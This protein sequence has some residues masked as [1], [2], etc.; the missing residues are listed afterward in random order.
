M[1]NIGKIRVKVDG[2][3]TKG[4]PFTLKTIIT[5]PNNNGLITDP[6]T[7]K[8]EPVNYIIAGEIFLDSKRIFKLDLSPGVSNNPYFELTVVIE[9]ASDLKITWKDLSGAKFE[10]IEKLTVG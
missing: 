10:Q 9:K 3:I 1:A 4:K 2:P 5:H 6:A 8:M 7:G